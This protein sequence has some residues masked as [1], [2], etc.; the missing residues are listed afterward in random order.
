MRRDS[1]VRLIAGRGKGTKGRSAERKVSRSAG[2]RLG[3]IWRSG[4]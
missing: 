3:R 4:R 1:R 2:K